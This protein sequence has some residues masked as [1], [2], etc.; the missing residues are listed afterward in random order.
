MRGKLA[1]S[2]SKIIQELDLNK[3]M[4][5]I[6]DYAGFMKLAEELGKKVG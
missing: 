1:H 3:R 4:C 5:S 6:K 2:T